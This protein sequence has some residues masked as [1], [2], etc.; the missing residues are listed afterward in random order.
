MKHPH[1]P[2]QMS[3]LMFPT[4]NMNNRLGVISNVNIQHTIQPK[5]H[6]KIAIINR[7]MIHEQILAKQL[8]ASIIPY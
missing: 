1:H 7:L 8:N 4:T 3:H 2:V 6:K 5:I